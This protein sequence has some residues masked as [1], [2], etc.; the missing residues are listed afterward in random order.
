[1]EELIEPLLNLIWE[2]KNI[3]TTTKKIQKLKYCKAK[4]VSRKIQ[5][6]NKEKLTFVYDYVSVK[7]PNRPPPLGDLPIL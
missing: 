1:M 2:P 5:R 3:I 7:R 6:R 4:H